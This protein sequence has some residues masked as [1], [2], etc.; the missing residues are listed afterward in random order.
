MA[1]NAGG[2]YYELDIEY[3]KLLVGQQKINQRLDQLESGFDNTTKAV[4]NTDRSMSKLSR[5]AV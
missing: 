2:I 4:T 3:Q 1:E 5:V